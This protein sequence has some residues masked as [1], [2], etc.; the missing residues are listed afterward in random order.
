M[1][2]SNTKVYK[3]PYFDPVIEQ[4]KE[5]EYVVNSAVSSNVESK[6]N[7]SNTNSNKNT[8]N[9]LGNLK[10]SD[11]NSD[12]NNLLNVS[13]IS[14]EEFE[15]QNI[16][17]TTLP[18]SRTITKTYTKTSSATKTNYYNNYLNNG[19]KVPKIPN[20]FSDNPFYSN[21]QNN[22]WNAP[23]DNQK[24]SNQKIDTINNDNT[25]VNTNTNANTINLNAYEELYNEQNDPN[26]VYNPNDLSY[27][28]PTIVP[29]ANDYG[30]NT[31]T[32]N[33]DIDPNN[34]EPDNATDIHDGS[35]FTYIALFIAIPAIVIFALACL[36]IVK[37]FKS[38]KKGRNIVYPNDK[39]RKSNLFGTLQFWSANKTNMISLSSGS[40]GS[41]TNLTNLTSVSN[42]RE[43]NVPEYSEWL[44]AGSNT[45]SMPPQSPPPLVDLKTGL[46]GSNFAM[47]INLSEV[48]TN[49]HNS[50]IPLTS[51]QINKPQAAKMAWKLEGM[52]V[53]RE[54]HRRSERQSL[55]N[56]FQVW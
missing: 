49:N 33:Q 11:D 18:P 16:I 9:I 56:S 17:K 13:N 34:T 48:N 2:G 22:Y 29:N 7:S 5:P 27:I 39:I 50:N 10:L 38:G 23:K 21:N 26:N 44:E 31:N 47:G 37:K 19:P 43:S 54:S 46:T 36:F 35:E 28:E 8:N 51:N 6:T 12:T 3:E 52:R 40:H 1:A 24:T 41:R 15:P 45:L 20:I 25:N 55:F 30:Y 14:K 42:D 53:G 4:N 32:L